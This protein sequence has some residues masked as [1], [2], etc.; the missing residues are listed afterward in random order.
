MANDVSYQRTSSAFWLLVSEVI[1]YQW[2]DTTA[3]AGL[4]LSVDFNHWADS[5]AGCCWDVSFYDDI[6]PIG[7]Y[8][9]LVMSF[10]YHVSVTSRL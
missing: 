9:D 1:Y 10:I 6:Q 2:S 5:N 7:R 3:A 8:V 4:L